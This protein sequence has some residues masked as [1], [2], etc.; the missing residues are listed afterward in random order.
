M[1]FLHKNLNAKTK[2]AKNSLRI[3]FASLTISDL[4]SRNFDP[5]YAVRTKI[6]AGIIFDDESAGNFFFRNSNFLVILG[7]SV[8]TNHSRFIKDRKRYVGALKIPAFLSPCFS[9][10]ITKK[11]DVSL[12]FDVSSDTQPLFFNLIFS[13]Q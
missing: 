9:S 8:D 6:F 1:R 4:G 7:I 11:H 10:K 13:H 12:D 5:T 2:I 3:F